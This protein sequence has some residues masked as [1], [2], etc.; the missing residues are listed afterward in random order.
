MPFIPRMYQHFN[1]RMSNLSV[2][3]RLGVSLSMSKQ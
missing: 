3:L 1:S 2:S